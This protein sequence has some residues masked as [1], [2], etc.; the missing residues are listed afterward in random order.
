[1]GRLQ[2]LQALFHAIGK[3]THDPQHLSPSF[4]DGLHHLDD[5]AAGGNEVL[6]DHH[7]LSRLQL[8]LNTVVTAM[9]LGASPDVAHGKA[10]Q[11]SRNG[12]VGDAGS[13]GP[14]QDL[15]LGKLSLYRIGNGLFHP[16]PDGRGGEDQTVITVDRALDPAGPG[17][18]LLGAKK[19]GAD[20][21]QVTGDLFLHSGHL[22]LKN[23]FY[24]ASHSGGHMGPP[25]RYAAGNFYCPRNSRQQRSHASTGSAAAVMG[26]PTTI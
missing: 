9:I 24:N 8:S 6:N 4:P 21:K 14:H 12:G 7:L 17:K 23:G 3:D 2:P 20:G 26:R 10:Q 19:D 13:A 25:L 18:G 22:I 5:A 1:M 11:V 15:G 16:V